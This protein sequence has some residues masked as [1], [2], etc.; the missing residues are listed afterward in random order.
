MTDIKRA[1]EAIENLLALEHLPTNARY[2]ARLA[3]SH[4]Q[5]EEDAKRVL[6]ADQARRNGT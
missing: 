5:A 3:I 1:R 2:Y 6:Q 4:L